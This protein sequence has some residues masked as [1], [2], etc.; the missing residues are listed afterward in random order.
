MVG[1]YPIKLYTDHTTLTKRH[2]ID[3]TTGR[4]ARWQLALSE[5]NLDLTY[6]PGRD[7]GRHKFCIKC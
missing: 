5:Y 3:D 7:L 4:I 2:K 1:R 6:V